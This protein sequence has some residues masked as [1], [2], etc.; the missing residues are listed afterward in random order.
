MRP[1]QPKRS[2]RIRVFN[3]T[4]T[5]SKDSKIKRSAMKR[6]K[7]M[8]KKREPPAL[9][10]AKREV[11]IRDNYTCQYPGCGYYSKHI[12]VH[13]KSKRSQRPDLKFDPSHMICLCR[14]HHSQTDTKRAEAIRLGLLETETYEKAKKQERE[15]A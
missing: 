15:A 13:H 11:R 5:V 9:T 14:K 7:P 1:K 2:D 4:L 10:R 6:G 12:D 8:K 3:S